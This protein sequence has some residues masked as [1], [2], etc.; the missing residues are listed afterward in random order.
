MVGMRMNKEQYELGARTALASFPAALRSDKSVADFASVTAA[1]FDRIQAQ[2]ASVPIYLNIDALPEWLLDQLA[3]DFKID[4]WDT[5]YS[6]SEKRATFRD[7]WRVHRTLGTKAAIETAISA[8]YPDTTVMEWYEYGGE[9]Y[10]FQLRINITHETINSAKM[11][12]VLARLNYYKNLRSHNEG[13]HYFTDNPETTAEV[14]AV[15]AGTG[16]RLEFH[17]EVEAPPPLLPGGTA[18]V[19]PASAQRARRIVRRITIDLSAPAP[20]ATA[21]GRA[22]GGQGFRYIRTTAAPI[23]WRQET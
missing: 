1:L 21:E 4:W 15:L 22:G 12:R 23:E 11:Q 20:A 8:I 5:E 7:H 14:Q 19:V 3:E 16:T 9:P 13:I 18:E 10:H 17:T 6:L 2:I